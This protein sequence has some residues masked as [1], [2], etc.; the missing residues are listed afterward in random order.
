MDSSNTG[1]LARIDAGD[2][3]QGYD[4][5]KHQEYVDLHWPKLS[6]DQVARALQLWE[7]KQKT[8]PEMPNRGYSFV[9]IMTYA[10]NMTAQHL[11]KPS[12]LERR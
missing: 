5:A 12:T 3:P 8:D 6:P 4:P 7:E 2:L 11:L 10:A 1:L 9:K